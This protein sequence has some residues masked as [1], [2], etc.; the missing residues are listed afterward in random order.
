MTDQEAQKEY[1]EAMAIIEEVANS[2]N[3]LIALSRTV[4]IVPNLLGLIHYLMQE[5]KRL[6]ENK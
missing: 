5:V 4:R 3:P 6:K 1:D 2:N